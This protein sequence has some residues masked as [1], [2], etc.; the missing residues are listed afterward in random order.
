VRIFQF[1][2]VRS[3]LTLWHFLVFG[4]IIVI[5]AGGAFAFLYVTLDNQL[6]ESL[7][8]DTEVVEQVLRQ[9]PDTTFV[10]V[11][12]PGMTG[13]LERFLE[14]WKSDGRPLYH[15]KYLGE[16]S[17][18]FPPDPVKLDSVVWIQLL[19]LADGSQWRVATASFKLGGNLMVIRLAV[20]EREFYSDI[21]KYAT[22]LLLGIPIGLLLVTLS[23]YMLAGAAL[24]PIDAIATTARRI[25]AENLKDRIPVKNPNDELGRLAIVFNDLLGRLQHSFEQLK[26]FTADASHELRTPLTA[27][28]SVGEVGLQ[29][30]HTAAEYKELIG[31]MLEESSRLTRLVDDLLVLSRADA[32]KS[33]AHRGPVDLFSLA[34]ETVN[35]VTVL[36]EEKDQALTVEGDQ[37]VV[38]QSDRALLRQA[39]LNLVDNAIKFSPEG[40]KIKLIVDRT[41]DGSGSIAV[42]DYGPGIPPSEQA[43]V[44]ER[45]H[46]ADKGRGHAGAG[47]GL[48]IARWAVEANGGEISVTSSEGTGSTFYVRL[49]LATDHP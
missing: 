48:A 14:I 7:K 34:Q 36:A 20:S 49:P 2:H 42:A 15:S 44:F 18:G 26:R 10:Q 5:Y 1:R 29:G 30:E 6:N 16:R 41:G 31:S 33:V 21:R 23:G 39:L 46:R 37:A 17:L 45:F 9:S 8:E 13:P 27:M 24:R 4:G 22:V 3:R 43:R 11:Q 25:G 40:S 47:L 38:V 28:R 19:K 35:L 12:H 32:G